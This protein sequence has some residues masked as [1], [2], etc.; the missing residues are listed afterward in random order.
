VAQSIAV[1]GHGQHHEDSL[2][3]QFRRK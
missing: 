1:G 3:L 2:D